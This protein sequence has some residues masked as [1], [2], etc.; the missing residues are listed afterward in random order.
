MK[1]VSLL[2]SISMF[3]LMGVAAASTQPTKNTAAESH[4]TQKQWDSFK[5]ETLSGTISIVNQHRKKVFLTSR[6]I[7]YDF[8]IT[9][10]TKITIDGSKSNFS[11]LADQTPAQASVTFIARADGNFAK[12]ITVTG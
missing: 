3:L 4:T 2:V 1:K 5:P 11:Q 9:K 6:K 10:S 12:S 8:K 7:P